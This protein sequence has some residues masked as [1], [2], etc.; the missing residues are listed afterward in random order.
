MSKDQ[1]WMLGRILFAGVSTVVLLLLPLPVTA[2]RLLFLIPYAVIGADIL[3]RAAKGIWE[4]E[5]LDENFLMA[6]AT[7]GAIVLGEA[8]ESVAV[9]LLYQLGELFCDVAV[10][11]SR[12]NISALMDVRPDYANVESADHS[13]VKTPSQDVAV[14]S[15]VVVAPG[16]RIPLDGVVLRGE[17]TLD[18]AALTGE[19]I[20]KEVTTDSV[21]FSG[22]INIDGLLA[23]QTTK[24]Y[25]ES[26]VSKI[27][28]LVEN[29]G[30]KKATTENFITKFARVYTPV[31]CA[32]A[33]LLA[34]LPPIAN[35]VLGNAANWSMWIERALTFIV[36]SCPC[37]LVVSIPLSYFGGIG[38]AAASGIL[39][40]GSNYL[41]ALAGTG[42]V[43]FD[44]TGTLTQGT[45][46]LTGIHPAPA[47][48]KDID[49]K[50]DA[51][52]YSQIDNAE[53]ATRKIL[54]YCAAAEQ[55]STHPIA[56]A[57][58]NASGNGYQNLL[59]ENVTENSGYGVSATVEGRR[60]LAGNRTLLEKNGVSVEPTGQHSET[61]VYVSIDERF[62]G[63]ITL[64]D[65]LKPESK[66]AVALLAKQGIRQTIMLTGDTHA[67]AASVATSLGITEFQSD[68]L[69]GDKVAQV[70]NY[71]SCKQN[72]KETLVFVGD[73]INDAPVLMRADV[74]LAMGAMGSDAAIT[75]A[76]VVLMDDNPL[77][78]NRAIMIARKCRRIV[79]QNIVFA[80]GVKALCLLLGAFGIANMWIAVLADV[81][82]MVLAV[83]NALRCL[84][85]HR[86]HLA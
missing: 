28:E 77:K 3:W 23:I 42:I 12:D 11:K 66:Q 35:L 58:V 83:L 56:K 55:Y 75:A 14:G 69:P 45:L 64:S 7:I 36:I 62:A 46:Q 41:E 18:M 47:Y 57:L 82:V 76:D 27:L 48:I 19:S 84:R 29:A 13:L 4:R 51:S 33:L 8:P 67:V 16:E 79:T 80:L 20:P 17:S 71:L 32:A 74:G 50:E 24:E 38:A 60:V 10:G 40:K 73:G 65:I 72:P 78:L 81:G 34:L 52:I 85:T 25:G 15:I 5:F 21:V 22:C 31:I 53:A 61:A 68:L 70:E 37:A 26:T 49:R 1:K 54:A 2:Q 39:V 6:I 43:V 30:E 63:Y 44:K 59:V 86:K 9:M